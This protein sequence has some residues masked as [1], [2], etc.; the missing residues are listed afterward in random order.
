MELSPLDREDLESIPFDDLDGYEKGVVARAF[1]NN[2]IK[3]GCLEKI[4]SDKSPGE[5]I[6]LI[7][8]WQLELL[9][10]FSE[11]D[12]RMEQTDDREL[13]LDKLALLR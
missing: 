3:T 6:I 7:Q 8:K 5:I 1:L 13:L 12:R 9:A 4:P 2:L 10:R 11:D